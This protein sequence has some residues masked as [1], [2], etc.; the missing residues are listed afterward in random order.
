LIPSDNNV[1]LDRGACDVVTSTETEL[2]CQF[3]NNENPGLGLLKV[4]YI[5]SHGI[6]STF[7][8]GVTIATILRDPVIKSPPVQYSG[9]AL[10]TITLIGSNFGSDK[11]NTVVTF[12]SG[13]CTITLIEDTRIICSVKG[14]EFEGGSLRAKVTILDGVNSGAI[15]IYQFRTYSS[16]RT[17]SPPTNSSFRGI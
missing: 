7:G 15:E 10:A 3:V 1:T 14:D 8:A 13:S 12:T 9:P 17:M 16:L 5:K 4:L 11:A 2:V 6:A